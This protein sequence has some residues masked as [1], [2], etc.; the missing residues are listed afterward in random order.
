[1]KWISVK[2]G[3]PIEFNKCYLVY[4]GG[5][6]YAIEVAYYGNDMGF[7]V[8]TCPEHIIDSKITHWAHLPEPPKDVFCDKCNDHHQHLFDGGIIQ[9]DEC[10]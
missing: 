9:C 2:D 5:M 7:M 3:K 6:E 8:G 1:M 10:R 4:L